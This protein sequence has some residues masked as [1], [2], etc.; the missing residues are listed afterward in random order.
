MGDATRPGLVV[1]ERAQIEALLRWC[2]D[3]GHMT[4][5]A[6]R[7]IRS[8][9]DDRQRRPLPDGLAVAN[10]LAVLRQAAWDALRH[11]GADL[12]GN[13]TPAACGMLDTFLVREAAD[14]R[15][16]YD[17]AQAEVEE[18]SAFIEHLAGL[19][20]PLPAHNAETCGCPVHQAQRFLLQQHQRR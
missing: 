8:V 14:S 7:Q 4:P 11:L 3:E 17:E 1:V 18:L 12:D 15:G 5:A 10:E 20:I 9:L 6:A 2:L 13:A 16:T 19:P